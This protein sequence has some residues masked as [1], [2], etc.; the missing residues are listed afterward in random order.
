[1]NKQSRATRIAPRYS[2]QSPVSEDPLS[3]DANDYQS[4]CVGLNV[5]QYI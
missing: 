3:D 2:A 4:R 5:T 1:M